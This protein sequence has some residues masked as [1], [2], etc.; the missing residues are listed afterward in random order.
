[1]GPPCYEPANHDLTLRFEGGKVIS[2]ER[3]SGNQHGV[4][5]VRSTSEL[6][7]DGSLE[8]RAEYLKDGT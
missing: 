6:M 4:T 8:T 5:E 1:M 3:V 7:P 2:H